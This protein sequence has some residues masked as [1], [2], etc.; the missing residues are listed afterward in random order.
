MY[1]DDVIVFVKTV[2]ES[3][4]RLQKVL[5]RFRGSGAGLKLKPSSN[6][7]QTKVH[8]LGHVVFAK[9]IDIQPK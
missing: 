9:G 7:L 8:Y 4:S 5:T 1:L 6:L 2:S 3:I